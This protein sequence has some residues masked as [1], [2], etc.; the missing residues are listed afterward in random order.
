MD[1][2]VSGTVSVICVSVPAPGPSTGD[3]ESLCLAQNYI[4]SPVV[5]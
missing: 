1:E 2:G 3:G 4:P 5:F